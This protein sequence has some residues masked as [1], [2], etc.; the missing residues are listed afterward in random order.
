MKKIDPDFVEYFYDDLRPMSH[1]VPAS[2][3]NITDVV[4][5]VLADEN[6]REMKSI[7]NSA[8]SW[9]KRSLTRE[10]MAKDAI[11]QLRRYEMALFDNYGEGWEEEWIV[12]KERIMS[13]IGDDL[14]DCT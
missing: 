5:Y 11:S 9:C 6:R 1:Y 2:L 13:N 7:V 4:K 3:D 12:V 8:N 14:A 10:G